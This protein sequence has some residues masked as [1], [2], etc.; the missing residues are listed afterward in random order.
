M[1]LLLWYAGAV[2]ETSDG[3]ISFHNLSGNVRFFP[4]GKVCDF[5]IN[6]TVTGVSQ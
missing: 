3:L 6:I 1:H 5:I 4:K 2:F